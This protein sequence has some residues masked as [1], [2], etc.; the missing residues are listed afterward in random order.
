V[1]DWQGAPMTIQMTLHD[2]ARALSATLH[3][4]NASTGAA[5]EGISTDSRSLARGQLFVALKGE[6]FDGH[7]YVAGAL[8]RGAV[9][10]I[11]SRQLDI[12]IPQIVVGDTMWAYGQL[13][14]HWRS[15]FSL[16]TIALT[17]SNGKTTVKEMLRAILV[18]H[19]GDANAIL[20]TEGNLNN[21]IGV[22]QM[23]LRLNTQHRMAVFE[24]GMNHLNEIDYLT[25]LVVPDVAL[26]IMAGTAHIGELG[27]RE[28]IAQ[29][30]GEIYAGLRDDGVACINVDDRYA[31]YWRGL[32]GQPGQSANRRR[33]TTFGTHVSAEVR[34]EILANGIALNIEGMR[35]EVKLNI[36]G[37]H[38]QRNAIA[39]AAGAYAMGVSLKAIQHGLE[40]FMGIAGRL[41]SYAGL[42][43]ATVIDD[44][45]NANP[46][47]MRAAIAVLAASPNEKLLVLGDMGELGE[48][49]EEMHAEIGEE[50]R[51]ANID[52]V[53]TLGALSTHY[54]DAFGSGATRYDNVDDLITALVLRMNKHTTVL[55][56]GSRFMKM[57]RVVEKI[58]QQPF[59]NKKDTH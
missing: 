2:C 50:A 45:Y 9:G 43:G 38:N 40:S 56:K 6:N 46:D 20:A 57:E 13:A 29:A 52:A 21:N 59:N 12:A 48:D 41:Q 27:S 44:T 31:D 8:A 37:P 47:S 32:I 14:Q 16:P 4:S 51:N 3:L 1:G 10:A 39:A 23:M 24:M 17:G 5:F 22:P 7:E 33:I 55:V 42:N 36:V 28:A 11:V 25:R 30:K 35:Y 19:V 18:A 15:R 53:F 58:V 26:I 49:A 34:G 54:V